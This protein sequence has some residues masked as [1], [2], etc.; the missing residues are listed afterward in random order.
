MSIRK[1][2]RTIDEDESSKKSVPEAKKVRQNGVGPERSAALA[3]TGLRT[4]DSREP[5]PLFDDVV[6][7]DLLPAARERQITVEEA[8][9]GTQGWLHC[10]VGREA[11]GAVRVGVGRRD[12]ELYARGPIVFGGAWAT[13]IVSGNTRGAQLCTTACYR[14]SQYTLESPPPSRPSPSRPSPLD[15]LPPRVPSPSRSPPPR[16]PSPLSLSFSLS[17]T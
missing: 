8:R 7:M 11:A 17:S 13:L 12:G 2:L 6:S 1:R 15:T 4:S 3:S 9:A 5:A 14:A 16:A 10:R